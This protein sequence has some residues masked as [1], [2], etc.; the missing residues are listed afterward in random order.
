METLCF[1]TLEIL[2]LSRS[3]STFGKERL[4]EKGEDDPMGDSLSQKPIP[5]ENWTNDRTPFL[6]SLK[7]PVRLIDRDFQVVYANPAAQAIFADSKTID[8]IASTHANDLDTNT[9]ALSPPKTAWEEVFRTGRPASV[10]RCC[11]LAGQSRH[12]YEIELTPIADDTGR[13]EKVMEFWCDVTSLHWENDNLRYLLAAVDASSDMIMITDREGIIE[14]VNP[15]FCNTTGYSALEIIGQNPSLLKS[16]YHEPEF[17]RRLW[18]TIL[19]GN[20]WK[21]ELTNRRKNGDLYTAEM[22]INPVCDENGRVNRFIA[23]TRDV[24][25]RNEMRM[26]LQQSNQKLR[27]ILENISAGVALIGPGYRVIESNRRL[28]QWFPS[29]RSGK[30]T[31]CFHCSR[32]GLADTPCNGCPISRTFAD[33][34][35]HEKI[36]RGLQEDDRHFRFVTSPLFDNKGQ[37]IAVI[38]MVEDV[39]DRFRYEQAEQDKQSLSEAVQSMNRVLGVVSH[40]LRAPLAAL[41]SST[42]YLLSDKD[43]QT[44]QWDAIL[45]IVNDEVIRLSEIVNNILEAARMNSG[46]VRWNWSIIKLSEACK[47]AF[48][49]A[50]SL[51]DAN[52]V[53][54][55]SQVTPPELCMNGDVDAIS[56]LLINLLTNAAKHTSAGSIAVHIAEVF[57]KGMRFIQLEVADTGEGISLDIMEKLG[58][59]FSLNSGCVTMDFIRGSGLGLS[60]CKGIVT[61]HGGSIRVESQPRNGTTF[62]VRLRADLPAPITDQSEV[63]I[64]Y[65]ADSPYPQLQEASPVAG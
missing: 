43:R 19:A 13:V 25:Q 35:V 55:A 39:T 61:A 53:D 57:E 45:S 49:V 24:T 54:L 1:V 46:Q 15:A 29:I 4:I 18:E 21:G 30:Q 36:S 17:Y 23:V 38:E 31:R 58:Q 40:E 26:S 9:Q 44:E 7:S 14:Y 41:R 62:T 48:R 6:D 16:D 12:Y 56:R 27:C 50:E 65:D 51:I 3:Q 63:V 60:I 52:Q 11:C 8:W 10:L 2:L 64:Q 34:K 47:T 22:C 32:E 33:G 42:E 20:V 37:V 28:R 59:A 5:D